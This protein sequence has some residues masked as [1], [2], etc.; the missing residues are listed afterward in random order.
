VGPEDSAGRGGS[1]RRPERCSVSRA[2]PVGVGD[3]LVLL[4]SICEWCWEIL[5][6]VA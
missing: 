5:G 6:I 4:A 3:P 2:L 1:G